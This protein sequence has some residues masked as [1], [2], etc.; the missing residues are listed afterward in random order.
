MANL[1]KKTLARLD[2]I[3]KSLKHIYKHIESLPDQESE[4][5]Q[6]QELEPKSES[7]KDTFDLPSPTEQ[8]QD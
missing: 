3:E 5:E 6:E 1:W 7:E 8:K 4:P 2:A